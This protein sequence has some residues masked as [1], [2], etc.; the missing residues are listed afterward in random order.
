MSD[1]LPCWAFPLKTI[2]TWITMS[3]ACSKGE[4]ATRA[5]YVT[6]W[7]GQ[8][9][10]KILYTEANLFDMASV[11]A[12]VKQKL[13]I[14]RT[15]IFTD[16]KIIIYWVNFSVWEKICFIEWY[17]IW[18]IW[19]KYRSVQKCKVQKY[20]KMTYRVF[21]ISEW[22]LIEPIQWLVMLFCKGY[23]DNILKQLHNNYC[24]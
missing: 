14:Y 24:D 22:T 9:L 5:S 15:Q 18:S 23:F 6:K 8:I 16:Y 10:C 4:K 2:V 3:K 7:H 11:E 20:L 21:L 17:A 13:C 12:G 19:L 1:S